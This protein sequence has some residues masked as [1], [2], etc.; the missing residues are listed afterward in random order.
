M[1]TVDDVDRYK[2]HK[3]LVSEL[4]IVDQYMMEVRFVRAYH[5][6]TRCSGV[7]ALT[8]VAPLKHQRMNVEMLLRAEP[9]FYLVVFQSYLFI[10]LSLST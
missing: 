1:P 2:S 10:L 9:S 5:A 4:H 7:E 8:F 3:G 6:V